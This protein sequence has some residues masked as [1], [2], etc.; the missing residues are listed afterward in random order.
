[1]FSP[2]ITFC[3]GCGECNYC[4]SSLTETKGRYEPLCENT[5][6]TP[7]LT[8]VADDASIPSVPEPSLATSESTNEFEATSK[9][10]SVPLQYLLDFSQEVY[11]KGCEK[12]NDMVVVRYAMAKDQEQLRRDRNHIDEKLENYKMK[13]T[14]FENRIQHYEIRNRIQARLMRC[15]SREQYFAIL[16]SDIDNKYDRFGEQCSCVSMN[17]CQC[18]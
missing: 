12:I 7:V 16:F 15:E 5:G 10:E 18:R 2:S 14:L 13:M 8:S 6:L 11:H 4:M 3:E 1:M 9:F 17:D